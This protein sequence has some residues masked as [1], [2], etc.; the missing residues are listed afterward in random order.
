MPKVGSTSGADFSAIRLLTRAVVTTAATSSP[1][2]LPPPLSS[3]PPA[4]WNRACAA[5]L[6]QRAGFG[7]APE[8]IDDLAGLGLGAAVARLVQGP[9]ARP[10][11]AL[12]PAWA[13]PEDRVAFREK[14][15]DAA[16]LAAVD[17][18]DPAALAT[19]LGGSDEG[20][21]NVGADRRMMRPPL[22]QGQGYGPRGGMDGGE[23]AFEKNLSPEVRQ[24]IQQVRQER[25][26]SQQ[27]HLVELVAW[28][29][30][31][32]ASAADPLGEKLTLFWHGHFATG[33]QKVQDAYL[34]WRQNE[35]FR[36]FARGPFGELTK[37][38]SRDGAMIFWLDLQ[39]SR[40]SRPNENFARELME[41]F[42]LGEGNYSERD[43][44]EAA[45]AFTGYRMDPRT[46]EFRFAPREHDAGAKRL[47]GLEG[48]FSGDDVVDLLLAQPACAR[49]LARKLWTFFADENPAPEIVE[50]VAAE[51]RA[52]RYDLRPVLTKVFT[53]REFYADAARRTQIKSPVQW[54]IQTARTLEIDLPPQPQLLLNALRQ[55]GQVL[56]QPPS[57]K[58]WDGGRAW[59]S[60]ATLLA[61]YNLAGVLLYG[62]RPGGTPSPDDGD[63][64]R[65]NLVRLAP[66]AL[67]ADPDALV[68]ALTRRL[69]PTDELA[70]KPHE[71]FVGYLRTQPDAP[72]V[73]DPT[74]LGLLHLM[75]STPAFQLC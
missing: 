59:I 55:M 11:P 47:F 46:E 15:K 25:R 65:V 74:V 32:M 9:A 60:A 68:C 39:Q 1:P 62:G 6:L 23:L 64:T 30:G 43:V 53:S 75:M 34:M 48:N 26:R 38:V 42:T 24:A 4:R 29:L 57:V 63:P 20:N 14:L 67:R 3:L 50:A 22:G 27:E 45:R 28:W 69:F 52:A 40:A 13:R 73:T 56:F 66:P 37:A 41:L 36:R 44:T 70:P 16:L 72:R 19:M 49:F 31:R 33:A 7:G 61:R 51:L 17:S 71:T 5:H 10:A 54:L 18:E 21:N 12:A 35:L 8:A 58:G 2:T